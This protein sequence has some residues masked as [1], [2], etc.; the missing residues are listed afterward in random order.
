[1]TDPWVK[2]LPSAPSPKTKPAKL[3]VRRLPR[4]EKP[5]SPIPPAASGE[6]EPWPLNQAIEFIAYRDLE[7]ARKAPVY[8]SERDWRPEH[9][10]PWWSPEVVTALGTLWRLLEEGAVCVTE[11]GRPV[12]AT[13]WGV[14]RLQRLAPDEQTALGPLIRE[15]QR[16]GRILIPSAALM[17]VFPD[18]AKADPSSQT[19][20]AKPLTHKKL[21]SFY[22]SQNWGIE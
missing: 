16:A 2:K 9:L 5:A 8:I 19:P 21:V 7:R 4:S 3:Q 17:K 22:K 11:D 6:E 15:I 10:I 14:D 20:A 13:R 18:L 12:P 1:M